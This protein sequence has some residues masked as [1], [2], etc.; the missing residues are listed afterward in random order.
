MSPAQPPPLPGGLGQDGWFLDQEGEETGPLSWTEIAARFRDGRANP[1]TLA[2]REGLE[3]WTPANELEALEPLLWHPAGAW[4]PGP[5]PWRRF[6]ARSVDFTIAS[7]GAAFAAPAFDIQPGSEAAG[8]LFVMLVFGSMLAEAALLAAF[9][10]T[11][12]KWLFRT[13][14]TDSAGRRP[15]FGRAL[16]RTVLVWVRGLAM[17]IPILTQITQLWAYRKL[18]LLGETTWDRDLDTAVHHRPTGP[19]P[20]TAAILILGLYLLLTLATVWPD[21]E[22]RIEEDRARRAI[23]QTE[24]AHARGSPLSRV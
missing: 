13:W 1:S 12:G 5:K 11:P 3:D 15:T 14:V 17:R 7:L 16:S 22:K 19:L 23:P 21:V 18:W 10:T 2:W 20:W 8:I 24:V 9:G 4:L 6:W